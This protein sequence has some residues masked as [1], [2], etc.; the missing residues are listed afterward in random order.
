MTK[1]KQ[2]SKISFFNSLNYKNKSQKPPSLSLPLSQTIMINPS[3]A[4]Y[5][6]LINTFWK[7]SPMQSMENNS[8][9]SDLTHTNKSLFKMSPS[10]SNSLCNKINLSDWCIFQPINMISQ[11]IKLAPSPT[12]KWSKSSSSQ[13]S[14]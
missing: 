4:Q 8:N 2:N 14:S 9:N 7:L 5:N 13:I 12:F 6:C 11:M 10:S 1:S 3:L